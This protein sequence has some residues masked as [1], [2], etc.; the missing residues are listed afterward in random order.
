[1]QENQNKEAVAKIAELAHVLLKEN[2]PD[3]KRAA[4]ILLALAGTLSGPKE[5]MDA[6]LKLVNKFTEKH[7]LDIQ[8][9]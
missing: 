3:I 4:A 2:D 6:L 8:G 9:R 5:G 7:L 1:M